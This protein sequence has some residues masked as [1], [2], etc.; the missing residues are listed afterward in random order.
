MNVEIKAILF[1]MDGVLVDSQPWHFESERKVLEA[2]SHTISDEE[3]MQYLG[4]TEEAFWLAMKGRF[5]I[6][7]S[8]EG[9]LQRKKPIY[10]AM[11]EERL[12][13]D[14]VL[15][16]TLEGLKGRGLLLGVA[17]SSEREWVDLIVR[18]LGVGELFAS[19]VS[20]DEV[21]RGKPSPDIFLEC[22]RR[23]GVKPAHCL[24]VEDA[25]AGIAA[26]KSAGM[27]SAALHG[28]HNSGVDLSKADFSI[29]EL[30]G[31]FD[32]LNLKD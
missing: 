9:M 2:Y 10:S 30:K 29:T 6:G 22:A 26:A 13:P 24:V 15:R 19:S 32:I 25:P 5:G 4:W 18:R 23:L 12:V 31:L 16:A 20:G 7:D 14:P 8:V 1:D 21:A 28:K 11:L 3:L 27:F 17:S